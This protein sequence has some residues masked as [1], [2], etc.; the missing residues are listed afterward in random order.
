[1]SVI[2]PEIQHQQRP[3]LFIFFLEGQLHD[4]QK[5]IMF[6]GDPSSSTSNLHHP[7]LQQYPTLTSRSAPTI[8]DHPATA[9]WP[10][11]RLWRVWVK[12]I[13]DHISWINEIGLQKKRKRNTG[14]GRTTSTNYYESTYISW[15]YGW[16]M[17]GFLLQNML[18]TIFLIIVGSLICDIQW[19]QCV[20]NLV[21]PRP[22]CQI[23]LDQQWVQ[24]APSGCHAFKGLC[25]SCDTV[26]QGGHSEKL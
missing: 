21:M 23:P 22:K 5:P 15:N 12:P 25:R 9:G 26:L 10:R 14:V 3:R 1:M 2:C 11:K 7:P 19:M 20:A 16:F 17:I 6:W 24:D 4:F 13:A 8:K 18:I